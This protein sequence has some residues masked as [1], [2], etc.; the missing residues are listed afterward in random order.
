M[1][2]RRF[3]GFDVDE[4]FD[5]DKPDRR[6]HVLKHPFS[7]MLMVCS[8]MFALPASANPPAAH[9]S[10]SQG[11][12]GVVGENSAG[13][14]GVFG[15]GKGAGL[16]SVVGTSERATAVGGTSSGGTGVWGSTNSRAA[17]GGEFHNLNGGDLIRAGRGTEFRVLQNG[18]V[19]VRGQ[20]IGATGPQGPPGPPS[21]SLAV[22]QSPSVGTG[23][24]PCS[25]RTISRVS[26]ACSVTADTGSCS[27]DA[28]GGCCAVCSP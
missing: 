20:V 24:C 26:G 10:T 5:V 25:S 19:V 17:S 18:D 21:R 3:S 23:A 14:D 28:V 12:R 27:N 7:L 4:V 22:C 1:S 8:L 11:V 6:R 2:D 9:L 15:I 13:G 16:R